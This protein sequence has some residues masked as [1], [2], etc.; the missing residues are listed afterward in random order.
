MVLAFDEKDIMKKIFSFYLALYN[1]IDSAKYCTLPHGERS[2]IMFALMCIILFFT[3]YQSA[4]HQ[5]KMALSTVSIDPD[6]HMVLLEHRYHLHDVEHAV[7]ELFGSD[8]DIYTNLTDQNR[9]TQYVTKGIQLS[10]CEDELLA[11]SMLRMGIE[12]AYFFVYQRAR[13]V[14][15]I[16]KLCMKNEVLRDIW[17]KQVNL[18]NFEHV[19]EVRSLHFNANDDWL[20]V[21][22]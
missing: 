14:T 11:L 2:K 8:T 21:T 15:K 10:M 7:E 18:V 1:Y 16:V 6:T 17:P 3:S 19:G 12:G 13:L 4:A 9:F 22:F 5:P 20:M